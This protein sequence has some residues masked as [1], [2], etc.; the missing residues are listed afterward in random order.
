MIHHNVIHYIIETYTTGWINQYAHFIF[1]LFIMVYIVSLTSATQCFATMFFS[2]LTYHFRFSRHANRK[3]MIPICM[4]N[5]LA[6]FP[7]QTMFFYWARYY[8][9]GFYIEELSLLTLVKDILYVFIM[10]LM[11]DF[12]IYWFHKS[13]HTYKW[14]YHHL[15]SRHHENS[16]PDNV[17]AG[18]YED[19][20]SYIIL[21][22]MGVVPLL[23]P[24]SCISAA[25]Y[26][27]M[28]IIFAQL[29]HSGRNISLFYGL[30]NSKLHLEHHLYLQKP[31]NF[32]EYFP[33][34][35]DNVF[36]TL[37]KPTL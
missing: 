35:W 29:N 26:S 18:I 20:V 34:V 7:L 19:V 21:Y 30:Y 31:V 17:W 6:A 4:L 32:G 11:Y 16:H 37:Q 5:Y 28:I 27:S 14:L 12:Q 24:V 25:I 9:A 23:F 10:I 8:S 1:G 15:H 2:K 33:I 13:L 36:G 3:R 22:I